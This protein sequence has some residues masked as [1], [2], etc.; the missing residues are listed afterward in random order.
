VFCPVGRPRHWPL[1]S[2]TLRVQPYRTAKLLSCH[3]RAVFVAKLDPDRVKERQLRD[4]I[5]RKEWGGLF[6]VWDCCQDLQQE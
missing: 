5:F 6:V 3:G 1:S 4:A 2:L